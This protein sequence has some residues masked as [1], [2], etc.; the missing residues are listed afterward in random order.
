[1]ERT[2]NFWPERRMDES[3][4]TFVPPVSYTDFEKQHKEYCYTDDEIRKLYINTKSKFDTALKTTNSPKKLVN[5]P[6]LTQ[7]NQWVRH[8]QDKLND[9]VTAVDSLELSLNDVLRPVCDPKGIPPPGA[10]I[11]N[12]CEL[13]QH[14][15]SIWNV[16]DNAENKLKILHDRCEL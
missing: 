4:G 15:E 14:L 9:I 5:P 7:V 6:P 2:R 3:L 16:A 8:V 13:I 10:E 12:T 11:R 1:M